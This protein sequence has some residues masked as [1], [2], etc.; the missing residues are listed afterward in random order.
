MFILR[1]L[2]STLL[3]LSNRIVYFPFSFSLIH[4][5]EWW[6]GLALGLV[7][8]VGDDGAVAELDL[9]VGLLLEGESV[10][11]PVVVVTV[12]VVLTGVST[13]R[14]LAVG[15]RHGS[16]SAKNKSVTGYPHIYKERQN[17]LRAGEKVLE[18]QGLNKV[19]V[20]DHAAVLDTNILEH[21]VYLVDLA[22]TLI[23]TLLHTEHTDIRL[24]GLLHG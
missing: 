13:T 2:F 16:L 17:N 12:G 7:E 9:A 24:H 5:L 21:L 8:G 6:H 10:L 19:R 20:P 14:L 23:Q 3:R 4:T 22:D 11:H 18:L 15:S 1:A